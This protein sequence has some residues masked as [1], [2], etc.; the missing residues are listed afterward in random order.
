MNNLINITILFLVSTINAKSIIGFWSKIGGS[1]EILFK[2]NGSFDQ[3]YK[4]IDST[5]KVVLGE[6]LGE[7]VYKNDSLT[8]RYTEEINRYSETWSVI[9]EEYDTTWK[10][11]SV[12]VGVDSLT[13]DT[14]MKWIEVNSTFKKS[15]V[16]FTIPDV[17]VPSAIN[18]L[19]NKNS[20]G[21]VDKR[22]F[23]K[24]WIYKNQKFNKYT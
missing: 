12:I 13:L 7:W 23:S 6:C 14:T 1:Q 9:P 19:E 10:N 16:G 21:K 18:L 20:Y 4:L 22:E 3:R 15:S 24:L 2:K 17:F 11:L 5:G 8:Y